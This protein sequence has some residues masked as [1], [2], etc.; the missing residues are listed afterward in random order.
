MS[1]FAP[2]HL[3]GEKYAAAMDKLADADAMIID[4]RGNG[5]GDPRSVALLISYF[6]DQRTRLNDIWSRDTG[7]TTQYWTADSLAGTRFGGVKPV[8]ILV[9]PGTRSGGEDFAYTMQAIKR[10]TVMGE[11]TWGGAH[12]TGSYRLGDHFSA[13]IPDRRSISPITNGNW[14]GVGVV[15]D[16]AVPSSDAIAAAKALLQRQLH[17]ATTH[18]ATNGRTSRQ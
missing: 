12:P 13:R 3:A 9:G 17:G 5:G 16:I 6:V 1:H 4:M 8:A 15:P 10:A 2:P 18:G 11:R 7:E 14:E